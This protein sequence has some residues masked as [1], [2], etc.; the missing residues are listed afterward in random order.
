[1]PT[2]VAGSLLERCVI[3]LHLG[4]GFGL[5]EIYIMSPHW[6]F[7]LPVAT[8]FLL[9]RFSTRW[10]RVGLLVLTVGLLMYNGYLLTD[11]LLSP[12]HVTL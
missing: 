9:Q 10:L 11:F 3:W 4:L 5:N 12:I 7:V 8:A 6:A 2:S 1:M